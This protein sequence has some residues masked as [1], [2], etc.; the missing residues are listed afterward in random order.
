MNKKFTITVATGLA[1][2]AIVL[3]PNITAQADI[4]S[5]L[6]GHWTFDDGTPVSDL[7][8]DSS[9]NNLSC[10]NTGVT[11]STPGMIGAGSGNFGTASDAY[12]ITA[13]NTALLSPGTGNCTISAWMNLNNSSWTKAYSDR[14]R[15]GSA[16]INVGLSGASGNVGKFNVFFRDHASNSVDLT[17][18]SVITGAKHHVV[19]VRDGTSIRLYVDG[20]YDAVGTHASLG[21]ICV[22]WSG[23]TYLP[24]IGQDSQYGNAC[25]DGLL[26]DVRYYSRALSDGGGLSIGD[27]A[28][29]DIAELYGYVPEPSTFALAIIG[30]LFGLGLYACRLWK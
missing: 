15:L 24:T 21:N 19:A 29:G 1:I 14:E 2:L 11:Q 13:P 4:I 17:G 30:L 5:N 25:A 9:P 7:A 6:Q 27:T 22:Q 23:D 10:T 20:V 8:K 12:T 26:D 28:G 3:L 18:R 16:T